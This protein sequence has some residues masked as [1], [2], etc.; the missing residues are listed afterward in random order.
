MPV[1]FFKFFQNIVFFIE[2]SYYIV[3]TEVLLDLSIDCTEIFLLCL[4]IFLG[5]LHHCLNNKHGNRQDQKSSQCHPYI[6]G[7]HHDK[8]TD[9]GC[10]RCD[11]LCQALVEAHLQCIHIVRYSGKDFAV[12]SALKVVE[13]K[14]VDFL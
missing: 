1:V 4:E 11:E 5:V 3:T 10:H 6:N 8:Y 14:S 9:Q 13:W 12:G 7:Q 2:Y